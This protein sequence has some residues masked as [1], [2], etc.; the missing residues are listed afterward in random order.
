MKKPI[1]VTFENFKEE[2]LES[3]LP[4]LVDFWAPWCGPCR[5]QGPIVEDIAK[6]F[7]SERGVTIGKLNVDEN[8]VTSQ[9]FQVMSIPTIKIFK[10]GQVVA[11]MIG[12]QSRE[13]IVRELK[14]HLT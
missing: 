5:V 7:A 8:P 9:N 6:E 14:A 3:T 4:V 11:S 10:D 1:E 2:V 12:L 13:T